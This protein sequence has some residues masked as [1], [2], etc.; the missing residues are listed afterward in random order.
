MDR[1]A[2]VTLQFEDLAVTY[3]YIEEVPVKWMDGPRAT[4]MKRE[5]ASERDRL[6]KYHKNNYCR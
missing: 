4:E 1:N 3:I 2:G 6:T 5:C